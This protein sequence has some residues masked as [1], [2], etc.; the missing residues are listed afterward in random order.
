LEQLDA[1]PISVLSNCL[2]DVFAL[3][4]YAVVVVAVR[5]THIIES[6]FVLQSHSALS[7]A[8]VATI[9]LVLLRVVVS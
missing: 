4:K 7:V 5:L 9:V 3:A 6:I 1:T 8:M 2:N